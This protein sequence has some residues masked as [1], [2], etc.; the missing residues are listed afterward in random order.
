MKARTN[1]GGI[2]GSTNGSAS[3]FSNMH[4]DADLDASATVAGGVIGANNSRSEVRN[5]IVEGSITCSSAAGGIVGSLMAP[6]RE[7]AD[8][9]FIIENNV[10]NLKAIN[11]GDT[12]EAVHRIVGYSCIDEGERQVWI[13]NPD[14]DESIPTHR[15]VNTRLFP[16]RLRSISVSIM[17]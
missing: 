17:L 14:W 16:L 8:G 7:E 15:R 11:A 10:V 13:E 6:E 9:V 5:S 4:V 3:A 12:P 1:L 2:A